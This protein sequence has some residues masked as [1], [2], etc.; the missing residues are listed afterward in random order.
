[1]VIRCTLANWDGSFGTIY[2][3]LMKTHPSISTS[4]LPVGPTLLNT[5]RI[6]LG[7]A[8]KRILFL[9]YPM[10]KRE[11]DSLVAVQDHLLDGY[12]ILKFKM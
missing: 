12:R 8:V 2:S 5:P 3:R 4:E 7:E 6:L 10:M 1:M 11:R 9:L